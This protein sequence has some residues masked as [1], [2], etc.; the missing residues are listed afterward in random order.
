[1]S[2]SWWR[3]RISGPHDGSPA[4]LVSIVIRDSRRLNAAYNDGRY[5]I[6]SAMTMKPDAAAKITMVSLVNRALRASPS[7][8]IA[9]PTS[10]IASP[11]SWVYGTSMIVNAISSRTSQATSSARTATGPVSA[12]TESFPS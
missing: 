3:M 4:R 7:V 10:L 8:N 11:R 5:A 1:M 2:T 12:S 6:C 9:A